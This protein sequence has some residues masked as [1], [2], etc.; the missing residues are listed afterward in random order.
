MQSK[1]ILFSI[2]FYI[3]LSKIGTNY[4]G[5]YEFKIWGFS[6]FSEKLEENYEIE[7]RKDF[8][9]LKEEFILLGHFRVLLDYLVS[10]ELRFST[11]ISIKAKSV[12]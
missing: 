6:F 11:G 2:I 3:I 8:V 10:M 1:V 12:V 4:Y 5:Y 9:I 7:P